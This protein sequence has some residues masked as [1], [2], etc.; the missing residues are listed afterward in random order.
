MRKVT[1]CK[2]DYRTRRQIRTLYVGRKEH[3]RLAPCR[4]RRNELG[5]EALVGIA[6]ERTRACMANHKAPAAG[7]ALGRIGRTRVG[8]GNGPDRTL[9]HA[10]L[11]TV[12]QRSVAHGTERRRTTLLI[13]TVTL[14]HRRWQ[15]C[16]VV[17]AGKQPCATGG[18]SVYLLHVGSIGTVGSNLGEDAVA[19]YERS[20]RNGLETA[21]LDYVLKFDK[22]VVVVAVA[23]DAHQNGRY[24]TALE[25][26]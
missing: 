14:Q 4:K 24:A 5:L 20:R 12:A 18:E 8:R 13:R 9:A 25:R 22:G 19:G 7:N 2:T 26:A 6:A 10:C 21:C 11:A 1:F 16:N 23:V 3:L 15:R 17:R